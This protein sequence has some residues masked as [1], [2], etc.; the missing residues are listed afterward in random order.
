MT[1]EL[2]ELIGLGVAVGGAIYG[3]GRITGTLNRGMENLMS[4]D[5]TL[6]QRI[7]AVEGK[8]V[9]SDKC[10]ACRNGLDDRFHMLVENVG[11]KIDAISERQQEM[12][13]HIR[14]MLGVK[15]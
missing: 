12:Y 13:Q 6:C 5:E 9:Q 8:A 1:V 2:V 14:D 7:K 11:E 15:Q 10:A 4:R 3:Y